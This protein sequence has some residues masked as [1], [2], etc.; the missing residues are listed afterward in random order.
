M[1]PIEMTS[2]DN[3]L[4]PSIDLREAF[5]SLPSVSQ[6]TFRFSVR[7]EVKTFLVNVKSVG[8]FPSAAESL[9]ERHR[10]L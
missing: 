6:A 5:Y 2:N 3:T 10:M 1:L 4:Q 8:S 9:R 7:F